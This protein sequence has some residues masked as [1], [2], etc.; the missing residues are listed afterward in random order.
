MFDHGKVGETRLAVTIQPGQ[1]PAAA[2]TP[3]KTGEVQSQNNWIKT[4][5]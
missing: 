5:S 1:A 4:G 3:G 2:R